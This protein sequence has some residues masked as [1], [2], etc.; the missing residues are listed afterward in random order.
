M[1]DRL[2]DEKALSEV[3]EA[4]N[5][6][7]LSLHNGHIAL[8]CSRFRKTVGEL[9]VLSGNIPQPNLDVLSLSNQYAVKCEYQP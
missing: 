9:V 8:Y 1:Y 2:F 4:I 6:S 7:S 5:R 3:E